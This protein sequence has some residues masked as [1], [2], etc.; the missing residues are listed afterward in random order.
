M[1]KVA[2]NL[3]QRFSQSII[4]H[5]TGLVVGG[6][7][8]VLG[9]VLVVRILGA[10]KY[11]SYVVVL[12]LSQ[13]VRLAISLGHEITINT[14]L[15]RFLAKGEKDNAAQLLLYILKKRGLFFVITAL[16][17]FFG[18]PLIALGFQ[19]PDL[20]YYIRLGIL[21]IGLEYFTAVFR[22]IF[23]SK[24]HIRG[25]I[26]LGIFTQFLNLILIYLFLSSGY[27]IPGLLWATIIPC[28]ISLGVLYYVSAEY[29]H[30]PSLSTGSLEPEFKSIR[31]YSRNIWMQQILSYFLGKQSDITIM[32]L[33]K[34]P[35]TAVGCYNIAFEITSKIYFLV[36]GTGSLTLSSLSESHAVSGI[37][38]LQ[39]GF[40]KLYKIFILAI[41]PFLVFIIANCREIVNVLYTSKMAESIP[42]FYIFVMVFIFSVLAGRGLCNDGLYVLHKQEEVLKIT[43]WAGLTNLLLDLILIPLLGAMGAV[44]AT[45]IS[46]LISSV[47]I[48]VLFWRQAGFIYPIPFI[49][50]SIAGMTLAVIPTFFMAAGRLLSLA[51][52]GVVFLGCAIIIFR[53]IKLFDEDEKEQM[54]KINPM[55]GKIIKYF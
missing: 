8:M 47:M 23:T 53:I 31:G 37:K 2:V 32:G 9:S 46:T 29:I 40:V 28:A 51:L 45:S 19:I 24:I 22:N 55:L 7:M 21:I 17:L 34:T 3:A 11:G 36:S 10:E 5:M 33:Y 35:L 20:A 39:T 16:V 43:F 48:V 4:W 12:S 50:R 52:E 15:P 42:M 41:L 18:A 13:L 14:Y 49:L 54:A 25:V 44:I 26:K 38:G 30:R 27:G 1:R 6:L